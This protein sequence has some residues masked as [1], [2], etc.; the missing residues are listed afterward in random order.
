MGC[1]RHGSANTRV[2]FTQRCII[3]SYPSHRLLSASPWRTFL[4]GRW[5]DAFILYISCPGRWYSRYVDLSPGT[6]SGFAPSAF[7]SGPTDS[8]EPPADRPRPPFRNEGR[9]NPFR[10]QSLY[11]MILMASST[12]IDHI[13]ANALNCTILHHLLNRHHHHKT[14]NNLLC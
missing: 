8:R 12:F 7:L 9:M 10:T 1:R 5:R 14:T 13:V 4:P 6:Q 11:R 2:L 3:S